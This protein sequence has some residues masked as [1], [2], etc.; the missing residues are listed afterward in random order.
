MATSDEFDLGYTKEQ[1]IA[2]MG[3]FSGGFCCGR[4]CGALTGGIATLGH[5]FLNY[6]EGEH[7]SDRIKKVTDRYVREFEKNSQALNV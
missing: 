5:F 7:H 4:A 6:K 3:G 2:L 1:A